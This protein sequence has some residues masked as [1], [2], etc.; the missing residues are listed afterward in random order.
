MALK[1]A[2]ASLRTEAQ[3]AISPVRNFERWMEQIAKNEWAELCDR[4]SK[5]LNGMR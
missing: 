1:C 4:I 3:S 2:F 5:R